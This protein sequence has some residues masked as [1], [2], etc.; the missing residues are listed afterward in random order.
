[1]RFVPSPLPKSGMI[2]TEALSDAFFFWG[3]IRR[4]SERVS[5]G[6]IACRSVVTRVCFASTAQ[7]STAKHSKAQQSTAKHSKE[8]TTCSS[9]CARMALSC[10]ALSPS[11]M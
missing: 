2:S 7:Q 3:E 10:A 1:M 5:L 8:S 9:M 11:V 6:G 4:D